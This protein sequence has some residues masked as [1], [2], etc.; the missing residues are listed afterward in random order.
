MKM[1]QRSQNEIS[2]IVSCVVWSG[3]VMKYF[4]EKSDIEDTI[5]WRFED[6]V[7]R[8]PRLYDKILKQDYGDYM[9]LPPEKDRVGHHFYRAFKK[10]EI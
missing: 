7:F 3:G 8:I 6:G 10:D 1:I 4:Y 5:S 2:N 9:Q